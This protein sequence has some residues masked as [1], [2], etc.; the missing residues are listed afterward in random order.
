MY[1]ES[2]YQANLRLGS[3]PRNVA[4]GRLPAVHTVYAGT[5]V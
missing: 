2:N 5:Y 4:A 1:T 3:M